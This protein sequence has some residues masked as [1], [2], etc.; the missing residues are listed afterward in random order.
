MPTS[1]SPHSPQSRP[2]GARKRWYIHLRR[3]LVR[4]QYVQPPAVHR[5]VIL[6]Y[7]D[8]AIPPWTFGSP[9]LASSLMSAVG[10]HS[11]VRMIS[12]LRRDDGGKSPWISRFVASHPS[13]RH[14]RIIRPKGS[15]EKGGKYFG[16]HLQQRHS[17]KL[18][19]VSAECFHTYVRYSSIKQPTLAKRDN[20]CANLGTGTENQKRDETCLCHCLPRWY[21]TLGMMTS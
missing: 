18:P 14:S 19:Q 9:P 12:H 8:I 6:G 13:I 21:L 15:S 20:T 7:L 16:A 3:R 11:G 5:A 4:F 17:A 10:N 1:S 2:S